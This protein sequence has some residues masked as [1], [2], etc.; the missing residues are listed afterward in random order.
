MVSG[1]HSLFKGYLGLMALGFRG[2]FRTAS[3]GLRTPTVDDIN[4]A[5][6][7]VRNIPSRTLLVPSNTQIRGI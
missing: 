3:D 1:I 7:T 5:L 4:P 2:F 6:P